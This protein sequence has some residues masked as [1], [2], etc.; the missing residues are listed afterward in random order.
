MPF[1]FSFSS[2]PIPMLVPS[3][4]EVFLQVSREGLLWLISH[5]SMQKC[6]S[7]KGAMVANKWLRK[8]PKQENTCTSLQK[9]LSNI[10]IYKFNLIPTCGAMNPPTLPHNELDPTAV[11][12]ISVGNISAVYTNTI[13]KEAVAPNLPIRERAI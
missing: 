9:V 12:R 3:F 2:F 10:S 13:A 4:L 1:P 8:Q 6:P 7:I 11:L 5:Q